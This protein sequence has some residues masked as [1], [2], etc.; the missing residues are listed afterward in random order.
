[1]KM[2]LEKTKSTVVKLG[3]SILCFQVKKKYNYASVYQTVFFIIWKFLSM[4]NS[5][6]N[7]WWK[8]RLETNPI[9]KYSLIQSEKFN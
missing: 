8:I 9:L 1:M 4:K 6:P 2:Y 5:M 3:N 7:F